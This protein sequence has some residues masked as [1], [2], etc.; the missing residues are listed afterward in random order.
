MNNEYPQ[1]I[2]FPWNEMSII[3]PNEVEQ[4]TINSEQTDGKERDEYF[5]VN[6]YKN[7]KTVE[8]KENNFNTII[9]YEI[10]C[11]SITL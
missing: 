3:I 8:I 7:V 2:Q 1:Q 6:T 5:Q 9:C 11:K 4:M 10:S